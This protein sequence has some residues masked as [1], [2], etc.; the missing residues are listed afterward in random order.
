[1]DKIGNGSKTGIFPAT[2]A[3]VGKVTGELGK[4]TKA[5]D[6]YFSA[7]N[8]KKVWYYCEEITRLYYRSEN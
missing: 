2:S 8:E 6:K 4:A 1:M 5:G 3:E 7:E